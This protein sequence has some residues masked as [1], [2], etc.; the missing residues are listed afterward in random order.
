[1]ATI[2]NIVPD[3]QDERRSSGRLVGV[4]GFILYLLVLNLFTII[5]FCVFYPDGFIGS[6]SYPVVIMG[7]YFWGMVILSFGGLNIPIEI[8]MLSK[9]LI[10]MWCIGVAYILLCCWLM[11]SMLVFDCLVYL[12]ILLT[13]LILYYRRKKLLNY[14][15][16]SFFRGFGE[17]ICRYGIAVVS[18]SGFV[19]FVLVVAQHNLADSAWLWLCACPLMYQFF[20]LIIGNSRLF[21]K[22]KN[23]IGVLFLSSGFSL[24]VVSAVL[25]LL[26]VLDVRLLWNNGMEVYGEKLLLFYLWLGITA[27]A[28]LG[29]YLCKSFYCVK[30]T[31]SLKAHWK[32][33]I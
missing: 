31:G 17:F 19:A 18:V 28:C 23:V 26:V 30:I 4:C 5:P 21:E 32:Q 20:M 11:P 1:M 22:R 9:V 13:G 24:I 15:T 12:Y 14:K 16:Y 7:L 27:V 8:R 6:I 10:T 33:N 29:L 25:Y 2:L 3:N